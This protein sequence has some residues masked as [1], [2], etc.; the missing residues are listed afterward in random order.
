MCP[1]RRFSASALALASIV[2]FAAGIAHG[3]PVGRTPVVGSIIAGPAECKPT[4]RD[5]A[6]LEGLRALGY[7]VGQNITIDRRCFRTSDEA[8]KTLR[9]FG[10]RKVDVILV[11]V[12]ATARAARTA[13]P[14]IPIVC[15]S[16]GDPLANGL[17]VS[18]ARPGGNV[19]GLASQSA[20]LIGKRVALL[21]EVVPGIS[22]VAALL[23]PDNPGTPTTLTALDAAARTLGIEISRVEFRDV[24]D[25]DKAF[26]AASAAG[27]RAVVIQD[28]PFVIPG[29]TKIAELAL[30]H[31]LPAVIGIPEAFAPGILLAYGPSR[32]EM[33]RR[34]A[35]F[36]DKILKG[37][38]AGDLP[39]EQATKYDLVLD[40]RTAKA[41]G[42]TIPASLL[43]R[44]DRVLE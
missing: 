37:A 34:A 29:M 12:P 33:Y 27:A 32:I 24:T 8:E 26:R 6:F 5:E 43:L 17:A 9:E 38:R 4:A 1:V 3:Q 7:A 42:L 13:T 36:V 11:G 16:C 23:N 28:D 25:F 19:T 30:G 40:R 31:R 39:F 41:L 14:D 15:A 44:A 18:L 35:T 22:R 21:K 2:I 20:E 10:R